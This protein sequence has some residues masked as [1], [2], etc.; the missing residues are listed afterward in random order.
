MRNLFVASALAAIAILGACTSVQ[1]EGESSAEAVTRSCVRTDTCPDP[2]PPPP[3][4]PTPPS[5]AQ[6]ESAP[7]SAMPAGCDRV[8]AAGLSSRSSAP[9]AVRPMYHPDPA[10]FPFNLASTTPPN[11]T[12]GAFDTVDP[13]RI[14]LVDSHLAYESAIVRDWVARK[15]SL[16]NKVPL[17][18][19]AH[20]WYAPSNAPPP[21]PWDGFDFG[22][23]VVKNDCA[24][25]VWRLWQPLSYMEDQLAACGAD[26]ACV[27]GNALQGAHGVKSILSTDGTT[28]GLAPYT[29]E[30]STYTRSIAGVR[31]GL[32][33]KSDFFAVN[34]NIFDDQDDR[35]LRSLADPTGSCSGI[36]SAVGPVYSGRVPTFTSARLA[37]PAAQ[38]AFAEIRALLNA[39]YVV[40][41]GQSGGP[42]TQHT[43]IYFDP[44]SYHRDMARR[45]IGNVAGDYW[46][47]LPGFVPISVAERRAIRERATRL[48]E[49]TDRYDKLTNILCY[50]SPLPAQPTPTVQH[51]YAAYV[52]SEYGDTSLDAIALVSPP[53]IHL[54]SINPGGGGGGT[55]PVLI[56]AQLVM[57]AAHA[58][59]EEILGLLLDEYART[60]HGCFNVAGDHRDCDWFPEDF[61][62]M[63]NGIARSEREV[64]YQTCLS[65]TGNRIAGQSVVDVANGIHAK[66]V[67][68]QA[69]LTATPGIG[70]SVDPD[71]DSAWMK[72]VR[73]PPT[74]TKKTAFG[75]IMSG[76]KEFG[77]TSTFGGG[78]EYGAYWKVTP[79]FQPGSTDSVACELDGAAHAGFTAH[80]DLLKKAADDVCSVCLAISS[81]APNGDPADYED[82]I[83]P[84]VCP[85]WTVDAC[86]MR[87]R[88][89]HLADVSLD[90]S[91]TPSA[92]TLKGHF[93]FAGE[94]LW[95]WQHTGD[96]HASWPAEPIDIHGLHDTEIVVVVPV[97]FDVHGEVH[98]GAEL[99]QSLTSKYNC[100]A[101][102]IDERVGF[103]PWAW[104]D[105][106]GTVEI[107][108]DGA[109]AGV[110]GHVRVLDAKLPM[111]ANASIDVNGAL[112]F[113]ADAILYLDYLSGSISAFAELFGYTAEHE[114]ASWGGYHSKIPIFNW[115][116]TPIPL[117]ILTQSRWNQYKGGP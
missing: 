109:G 22:T 40:S 37:T 72:D 92:S 65:W 110:R 62:P 30:R 60:D 84:S 13:N 1:G 8:L 17:P 91:V 50:G 69:A 78:Y 88:F 26:L 4:P 100:G 36:A 94:E 66:I 68:A 49:L 32:F 103:T 112:A 107:G 24:E 73:T 3:P 11:L 116:G 33:A 14:S 18:W 20:D 63:L 19:S 83:T 38:Q 98:Y 31:N 93:F 102:T 16:M 104:V 75:Q 115:K 106:F 76:A 80:A 57:G 90:A 64:D 86:K 47:G 54:A 2:N 46:E 34:A 45:T 9:G 101:P 70:A 5:L 81:A 96:Y 56:H 6:C 28:L 108:F 105:A 113:D 99:K 67:A 42:P 39:G 43:D 48:R 114:I 44:W 12:S 97:T 82:A 77:D 74:T 89:Q 55:D 15:G 59:Q 111:H 21:Q 23:V 71:A 53:P 79:I 10:A 52:S 41:I 87:Y 95:S 7:P 25:Y 27:A 61:A 85:S 51:D 117:P 29:P 35:I 58:V